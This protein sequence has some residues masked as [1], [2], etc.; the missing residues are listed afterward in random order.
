[1]PKAALNLSP[2]LTLIQAEAAAMG[3]S[4]PALLTADVSRWRRLAAANEPDLDEWQWS[5]L[6][7]VLSGIEAQRILTGIDDLPSAGSIVAELDDWA[8]RLNDNDGDISR[9]GFLRAYVIEWSPLQ[10]AA[11]LFW[12]RRCRCSFAPRRM[13]P[14]P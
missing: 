9:V 6:D 4:F 7:H 13:R 14:D 12:I 1:M 11:A 10:V 8:A 3:V 5:C 2:P